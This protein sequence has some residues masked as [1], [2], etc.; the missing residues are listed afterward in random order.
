MIRLTSLTRVTVRTPHSSNRNRSQRKCLGPATALVFIVCDAL[1]KSCSDIHRVGLAQLTSAGM[2]VVKFRPAPGTHQYKAVF[3]GTTKYAGSASAVASFVVNGPTPTTTLLSQAGIQFNRGLTAAVYGNGSTAPTGDVSFLNTNSAN[4]V[5]GSATLGN[6]A[7]GFNLLEPFSY[8]SLGG[9]SAIAE[10]DFNA[11][12]IQ[13]IAVVAYVWSPLQSTPSWSVFIQFGLG[14]GSFSAPV[15]GPSLPG[16]DAVGDF[17]GDG[18][19]DLAVVD[20]TGNVLILLGNGDGTFKASASSQAPGTGPVSVAVADFN[21]DGVLDLAIANSSSNIISILLG[22]GD[23]TF[24]ATAANLQPGGGPYFITTADFNGDGISDLT[25]LSRVEDNNNVANTLSVY[26]GNG[27]GTFTLVTKG[28]GTGTQA[29]AVA[30]GDFNADGIE[31]LAIVVQP[32]S[33]HNTVTVLTG[34]GDGTFKVGGQASIPMENNGA[35]SLLKTGDFNGDSKIDLALRSVSVPPLTY[36]LTMLLGDGAGGFSP[37]VPSTLGTEGNDIPTDSLV[38]GDWNGD[39][40]DDVVALLRGYHDPDNLN[41]FLA[42]NQSATAFIS[43]MQPPFATGE[44]VIASYPGDTDHQPS[45]SRVV[46]LAGPLGSDMVS[47]TV[48]P[49]AATI[50]DR[51]NV[52]LN[53]TVVGGRGWLPP[54]DQCYLT[55]QHISMRSHFP[56]VR[57]CLRF[58]PEL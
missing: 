34:N 50:T 49:S 26:L 44:Q 36:T 52:N 21:D 35:Y 7:A 37:Q 14:D 8:S 31:D 19:L 55:A 47:V 1:A 58:P 38:I 13:D 39:G 30:V 4:A 43:A 11:D 51:Q 12:G 56:A 24:T 16:L 15:A 9:I 22:N 10:G 54:R 33:S 28:P 48:T 20:V 6:G 29:D 42:E 25:V 17:N 41:V 53:V 40:V 46:T 23:G 5:L 27:D 18:K 32:D 3:A 57:P 2:A 45:T